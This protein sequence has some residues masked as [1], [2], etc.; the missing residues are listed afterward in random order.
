[1]IFIIPVHVPPLFH[2]VDLQT[3]A[4]ARS[5]YKESEP[6]HPEQTLALL[7]PVQ[8]ILQAKSKKSKQKQKFL[9]FKFTH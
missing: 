6:L 2:A 4:Y 5:L 7:H 9:L 1:M 8:L 3:H